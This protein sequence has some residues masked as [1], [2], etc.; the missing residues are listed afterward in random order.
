MHDSLLENNFIYFLYFKQFSTIHAYFMKILLYIG[1]KWPCNYFNSIHSFSWIIFTLFILTK[2]ISFIFC[3]FL[4]LLEKC[5]IISCITKIISFIF[6]DFEK[7]L[8]FFYRNARL[9]RLPLL[10][11]RLPRS[12]KQGALFLNFEAQVLLYKSKIC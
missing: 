3:E 6:C 7:N 12:L 5:T 1:Q 8:R 9:S 10:L 4:S 2:I 11:S